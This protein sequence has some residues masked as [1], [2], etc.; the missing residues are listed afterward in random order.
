MEIHDAPAGRLPGSV[1]MA[2]GVERFLGP[3]HTTGFARI[4]R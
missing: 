2:D 4:C 3:E 1:I